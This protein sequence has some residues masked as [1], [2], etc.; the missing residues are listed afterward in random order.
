MGHSERPPIEPLGPA[1]AGPHH[2]RAELDALRQATLDIL[3]TVGV[4]FP[5][6]RALD[7]LTAHGVSVDRAT[8]VARFAPDLVLD[9]VARA[10][11]RFTL[12]AR[13]AACDLEV[14]DGRTYCTTA[15]CGASRRRP[16]SSTRR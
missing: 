6:T 9:A 12:G 5:S 11:R 1:P 2:G 15:G 3:E 16:P 8:R 7:V 13:D 10:P 4:Q 14:G